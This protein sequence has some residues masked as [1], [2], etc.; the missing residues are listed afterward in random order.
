MI[1]DGGAVKSTDTATPGPRLVIDGRIYSYNTRAGSLMTNATDLI[2]ATSPKKFTNSTL[3][4]AASLLE[5]QQQDLERMRPIFTD[6]SDVC[7]LHLNYQVFTTSQLPAVLQ[8][9]SGYTG[10]SCGF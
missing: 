2:N 6:G 10:G 8:R 7:S 1:A 5:S 4:N 3:E 9:P